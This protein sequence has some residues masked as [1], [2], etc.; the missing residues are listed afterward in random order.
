MIR[1]NIIDEIRRQRAIDYL[2]SA[3][4]G[5]QMTLRIGEARNGD[6]NARLHAMLTDISR[7]VE[8]HGKKLGVEIWKRLCTAAYLREIGNQPQMVPALDGNGFDVI[9]E[10]TSQMPMSRTAKT[11]DNA[12]VFNELIDWVDSF[13]SQNGV[14]WSDHVE[15][16]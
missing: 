2:H 1:V 16:K 7:Q 10:R 4:I 11:P 8:W 5:S 9:F 15:R 3:S 14:V 13:G 6:Q 12:P